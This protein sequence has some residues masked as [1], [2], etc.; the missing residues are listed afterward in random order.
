M[1]P[2]RELTKTYESLCKETFY[3]G[4]VPD[5]W[6]VSPLFTNCLEGAF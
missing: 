2:I 4:L 6:K 5:L 1:V 3:R